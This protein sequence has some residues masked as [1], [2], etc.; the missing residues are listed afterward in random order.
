M[1]LVV[2]PCGEKE[3]LFQSEMKAVSPLEE[4]SC[5]LGVDPAVRVE[6]KPVRK[7]HEQGGLLTKTSIITVEQRIKL[8]NTRN[9]QINLKLLEQI[10]LSGDD[11]LKVNGFRLMNCCLQR[12]RIICHFFAPAALSKFQV[13]CNLLFA[14]AS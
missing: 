1:V 2:S 9:D 14:S 8:N 7:M 5:S 3:L 11:K 12:L 4:F 10:P 13:L 6:Y